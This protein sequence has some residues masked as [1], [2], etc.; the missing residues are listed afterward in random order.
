MTLVRF[1]PFTEIDILHRQ[2]DRLFDEVF[3]GI[4]DREVSQ[5]APAIELK[6]TEE[7]LVLNVQLPGIETKDLDIR[8]T[9]DTVSL[10]GERRREKK[11]SDRGIYRS[12]FRYGEFKRVVKLPVPVQNDRISADY[13]DGILTLTLPK[14]EEAVNRVVKVSLKTE[15][16]PALDD[17]EIDTVN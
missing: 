3:D 4:S 10:K 12:E 11:E 2:M 1:Q 15:E 16:K 17:A 6:D 9:R 7:A 14:V 13:K 8:V 5:T